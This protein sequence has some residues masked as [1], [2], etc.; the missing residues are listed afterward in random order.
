[1]L[2]LYPLGE[3]IVRPEEAGE[4]KRAGAARGGGSHSVLPYY[5]HERDSARYPA[6]A[7][8]W[9][10]ATAKMTDFEEP[11]SDEEKVKIRH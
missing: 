6:C 4:E 10:S 1:M 8:V 2:P 9:G 3:L 7:A 11:L 5:G